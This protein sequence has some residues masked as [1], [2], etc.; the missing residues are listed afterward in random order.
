MSNY[1]FDRVKYIPAIVSILDSAGVNQRNYDFA[2][3]M[4][5]LSKKADSEALILAWL[6][7]QGKVFSSLPCFG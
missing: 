4:K 6:R 1:R 3:V 2:K 5:I 7:Y